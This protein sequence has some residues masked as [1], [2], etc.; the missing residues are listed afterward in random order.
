VEGLGRALF[1]AFLAFAVSV[2]A[3]AADDA[4]NATAPGEPGA[5][6]AEPAKI[7]RPAGP[8]SEDTVV[9]FNRP[10][11]TF[12]SPFLGIPPSERAAAAR[13]RI[14]AVLER[15]G[16]GAVSVERLEPGD[17]LKID[18]TLAFVLTRDD[19][20]RLAGQTFDTLEHDTVRVLEQT[21]AE[22]REARSGKLMLVASIS[23][24]G[25]P[26]SPC[27]FG[28]CGWAGAPCPGTC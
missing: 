11:V 4:P 18:D 20:D 23:A 12:R 5:S 10:I 1:A 2:G 17:A 26:Y 15:G 28:C 19:V 7:G 16:P 22:T 6:K 25:A 3:V 9:V 14:V 21:I 8:R 24:F 27:C 13:N